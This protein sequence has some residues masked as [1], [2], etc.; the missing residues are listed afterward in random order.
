MIR[1]PYEAPQEELL[2]WLGQVHGRG[3]VDDSDRFIKLFNRFGCSP[4]QIATRASEISDFQFQPGIDDQ[5]MKIYGFAGEDSGLEKRTRVYGEIAKRNLET[6]YPEGTMAPDHLVHVTCTGYISPSAVQSLV[7]RRGWQ[8]KTDVTHA[9]HMGCYAALPAVRMAM[10]FAAAENQKVDLVHTEM[11]SLHM[12]AKN[13]SPEQMV[14]QSLF[15]DGNVKYSLQKSDR[16]FGPSGLQILA[17]RERLIPNSQ[18]DMTWISGDQG[19]RMT[20]SREVPE[21]IAADLPSFIEDL[22]ARVGLCWPDERTRTLGAIHP[23]GP[24]IIDSVK[25]LLGFQESQV[26]HSRSVLLDYGNMSSATLPHVWD[27]VL[28]DQDVADGTLILSVAFG[29]GLTM[30]GLLARKVGAA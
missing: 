26:V 5:K 15:A 18:K 22:F 25:G 13:H 16:P 28:R 10:G 4:T 7:D 12:E 3:A 19:M 11:C 24:K 1:P 8:G 6:F 29:P 9:Y 21:R 14:V 2:H 17:V 27:R 30:F 23:G 20:L